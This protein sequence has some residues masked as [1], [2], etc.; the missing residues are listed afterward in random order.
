MK[1]IDLKQFEKK[2]KIRLLENKDYDA[3]TV[4]QKKCFPKMK[5][6]SPEQFKS[7]VT[8]FPEGQVCI[9]YD[10]KLIASAS[11]MILNFDEYSS[12]H[13]W[14]EITNGGFITNHDV[15]G[16]TLYGIEIMTSPDFR[17]LKLSRRLYNERKNIARSFNLKRIVIGGRIPGYA[18]HSAKMGAREYVE[19]VISK[20]LV[21]PVLTP[22]I[23][24]NFVLI[25]LIPA[26][27]PSDK[28]SMGYATY[29]EWT[30][31]DYDP[32][33]SKS[34]SN[35]PEYVRVCA[36]Q[37]LMR[38]LKDFKDFA[39]YCEYF[40][41]VASDYRCDFILFPEMFTTQLLT[42]M[43][44]ERPG[45][46]MRKLSEYTPKYLQVFTKLAIKYN[47]N[48]IGGSHFTLEGNDLYNISYLFRR[49]GTIGKQYKIHITPSERK[50]WGVKPGNKVEVFDTDKG[51]IAILICYDIEFPELSRIA[52]EKGAN[53]IFVPFNTD[54]RSAY[55]RVRYCAH[56]RCV[57]NQ[58]YTVIAGC[59]GNI[60]A[61]ENLD[62]HYAQSAILTP[63][64]IPFERDGIAA[65]CSP[66][67][68]TL[69]FHDLDV[70]LIKRQQKLGS[71][72]NWQDRRKDLYSIHFKEDE[73]DLEL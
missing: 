59:V 45:I 37:Y 2:L 36:I 7:L 67:I 13:N 34:F 58:V 61:V 21:D 70:N 23:S 14:N 35:K 42:F 1:T 71:V 48:I 29:L 41:D 22:Q 73:K 69:I 62:I 57:E 56:A 50:W 65:E 5:P 54:E 43:K 64:D 47:I 12:D 3:I 6:W 19:R 17:G 27:L 53:I 4:L 60:P 49:D 72:L 39:K 33:S 10:G 52:V 16:D 66:N 28:E 9:E 18:A 24:N 15:N 46:A 55:L 38:Q 51:K 68:E 20:E 32:S 25:R 44:P 40:I 26:Y 31:I 63:S 30:N 8:V 11:C